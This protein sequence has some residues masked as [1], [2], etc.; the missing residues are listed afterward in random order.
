MQC[1]NCGSSVLRCIKAW[2]DTAETMVR[3][4]RCV[5]CEHTFFTVEAEL[6]P[7]ALLQGRD[8][9]LTRRPG[10]KRITFG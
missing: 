6:P 9:S 3:R 2:Q 7:D 4:R 10:F 5:H 8:W 1:P